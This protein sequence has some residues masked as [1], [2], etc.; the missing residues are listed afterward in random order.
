MKCPK[1]G[2]AYVCVHGTFDG[3]Q[4]IEFDEDGDLEVIDSEPTDFT[5]DDHDTVDCLECGHSGNAIDFEAATRDE[6]DPSAPHDACADQGL[7]VDAATIPAVGPVLASIEAEEALTDDGP[8]EDMPWCHYCAA[9]H[10]PRAPHLHCRTITASMEGIETKIYH[11][12][13]VRSLINSSTGEIIPI[14]IFAF[15]QLDLAV[16]GINPH[17]AGEIRITAA[18]APKDA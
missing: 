7:Q 1:C 6:T 9:Y 3:T 4:K 18:N 8:T 17:D 16:D 12:H 5:W 10:G 11:K 14:A 15:D 2:K 13:I